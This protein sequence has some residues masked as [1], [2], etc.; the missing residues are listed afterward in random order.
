M[1]LASIVK[2]LCGL[3]PALGASPMGLPAM[4]SEWRFA[5]SVA[6]DPQPLPTPPPQEPSWTFD[7]F[8]YYWSAAV[9]GDLTVDGESVDLEGGGDGFS[10]ETALSGFLGHFE[11]HRGPWSF[12]LAPIFVNVDAS[13]SESGGVDA[14]VEIKAQIHEGFVARE[15]GGSWDWLAGLRY[16]ELDTEMD[17][18]LGGVLSGTADSNHAWIDPIVGLRYHDDLGEHWSVHARADVGGFGVGSELAWNAS[19]LLGYR[20]SPWCAAVLGYRALS[21]DFESGSGSDRLAYDLTMNGP[22]I[23]VSFSF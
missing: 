20:F 4:G 18:S 12:A 8:I 5:S 15:L 11:A 17:L 6:Q 7:A 22:I 13:G 3:V 23:G 14:D 1:L 9:S 16:Y 10:G 21:L 19:A 2:A